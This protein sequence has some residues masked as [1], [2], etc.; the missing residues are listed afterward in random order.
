MQPKQL[1]LLLVIAI[2]N[3]LPAQQGVDI[4]PPQQASFSAGKNIE[5]WVQGS[6]NE[7]TSKVTAVPLKELMYQ[8]TL[9]VK[10]RLT[11]ILDVQ[12]GQ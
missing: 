11:T 3:I 12:N 1:L 4:V 6:V 8:Y 10:T 5:G 7:P 9:G 2:T